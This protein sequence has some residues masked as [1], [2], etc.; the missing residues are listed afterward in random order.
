MYLLCH[1][2]N[3]DCYI[4][5]KPD[6]LHKSIWVRHTAGRSRTQPSHW[7]NRL[8]PWHHYQHCP[9]DYEESSLGQQDHHWQLWISTLPILHRNQPEALLCNIGNIKT[10]RHWWNE[11]IS[12]KMN[13]LLLQLPW[14]NHVIFRQL[15]ISIMII[16]YSIENTWKMVQGHYSM[17]I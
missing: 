16:L 4:Q 8:L 14:Y 11:P 5:H 15:L 12:Q 2:T 3:A 9:W 6:W 10:I 17:F 13:K 7:P 1:P